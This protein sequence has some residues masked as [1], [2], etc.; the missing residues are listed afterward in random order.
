MIKTEEKEI[1]RKEK[2]LKILMKI[3]EIKT[4]HTC[5]MMLMM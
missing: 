2:I 4:K 5:I 1:I 3:V